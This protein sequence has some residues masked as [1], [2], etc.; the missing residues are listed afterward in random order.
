MDLEER[1]GFVEISERD[2]EDICIALLIYK[3]K[4]GRY[5]SHIGQLSIDIFNEFVETGGVTFHVV[6]KQEKD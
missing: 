5:D 6:P 3:D 4:N 1:G 2:L